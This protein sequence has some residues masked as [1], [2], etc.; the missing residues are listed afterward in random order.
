M[1]CI[2]VVELLLD[3]GAD[4][5]AVEQ[6]GWSPLFVA[7]ISGHVGVMKLLLDHGANLHA[8]DSV[9]TTQHVPS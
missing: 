5:H 3:R 7:S 2:E 1:N 9:S 4:V 8:T 6:R